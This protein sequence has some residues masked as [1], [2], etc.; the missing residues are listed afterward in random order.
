MSIENVDDF[1]EHFGVKGMR[2]GVRNSLGSTNS[3]PKLS[4]VTD[5]RG[6][7]LTKDDAKWNKKVANVRKGMSAYNK[8]ADKMN[9]VVIPKINN[10]PKYKDVDFTN[11]KN[12]KIQEKYHAEYK[13]AF[14]KEFNKNLKAVYG[15]SPSGKYKVRLSGD[16]EPGLWTVDYNEIKHSSDNFSFAIKVKTNQ[17][18]HIVSFDVEDDELI[19]ASIDHNFLSHFGIKGMRWGVRRENPSGG[20]PTPVTVSTK[21]NSSKIQTKGGANHPASDEAKRSAS[22]HQ[23]LKKSGVNSLSNKEMQELVTRLNLEQQ[24]SKLTT[25]Q[26]SQFQRNV[27]QTLNQTMSKA[28]SQI[29]NQAM[30][31]LMDQAM[32]KY[33]K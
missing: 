33:K 9:A 25:P 30:T 28:M 20:L 2:W 24:L 32:K 5:S 11:P 12:S 23:K 27:E 21:P 18:G 6:N 7:R 31:R 17:L 16:N 29:A 10:D 14:E 19:Q 22:I 26:K 4:K 13:A 8:T 1:L 3:S 15:N